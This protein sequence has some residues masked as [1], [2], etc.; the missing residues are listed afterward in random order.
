[1]ITTTSGQQSA[2]EGRSF[3]AALFAFLD[4]SGGA[5]RVTSWN[6]DMVW[7]GYTWT[8]LGNL[9]GISDVQESEKLETSAIDLTM[10]AANA[11]VLALAMGEA[12]AYR[13]RTA[14]IYMCPML[15]GALIDTPIVVWSGYMDTMSINYASDSGGSINVRC[16]PLSEKLSRPSALRAN[17]AQQKLVLST[18]LGFQYQEDLIANPQVWLSKKFQEV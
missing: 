3:S 10:N 7:G 8:G 17:H 9:A 1:M 14:T 12:E 5:V 13:G 18:D 15:N 11:T 2:L 4:F 16:Y 6:H